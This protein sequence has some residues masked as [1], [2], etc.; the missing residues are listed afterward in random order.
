[1][2]FTFNLFSFHMTWKRIRFNMH[3]LLGQVCGRALFLFVVASCPEHMSFT[4]GW[5]LDLFW[6]HIVQ[7]GTLFHSFWPEVE[8]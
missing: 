3:I 5:G 6:L 2:T 4:N 8:E 1:M 7:R